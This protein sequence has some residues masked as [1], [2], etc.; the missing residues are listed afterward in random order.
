MRSVTLSVEGRAAGIGS[1][2]KAAVFA[3][4]FYFLDGG[5]MRGVH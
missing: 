3:G 1:G 2:S 4:S 5:L